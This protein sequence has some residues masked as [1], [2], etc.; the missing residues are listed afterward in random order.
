MNETGKTIGTFA[1]GILVGEGVHMGA[2]Y[3]D[4]KLAEGEEAEWYKKPSVWATGL[5]VAGLLYLVFGKKKLSNKMQYLVGGAT[6][7]LAVSGGLKLVKEKAGLTGG[8]A[9]VM[10][11]VSRPVSMRA[12]R[13]NPMQV[14]MQVP[15]PL[16]VIGR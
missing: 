15:S 11:R 14:P 7:N 12:A 5:G 1:T 3:W 9:H 6:A 13:A 10:R 4:T 2:E 16:K 8:H